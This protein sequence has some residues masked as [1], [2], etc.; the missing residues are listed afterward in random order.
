LL[1]ISKGNGSWGRPPGGA[2][3]SRVRI[4]HVSDLHAADPADER[5]ELLPE[6]ALND[7]A[8][9]V[10]GQ[11]IH[12]LVCSGDLT[13][14]GRARE[15]EHGGSLLLELAMS[16][17]EL[18]PSQVILVPGNHEIDLDELERSG[19]PGLR[20]GLESR[21]QVN[22]ILDDPAEL[23]LATAP[24]EPWTAFCR[25][26]YGDAQPAQPSPLSFVH[27]Y[28]FGDTSVG[29]AALNSAWLSEGEDDQGQLLLGNHQVEPALRAISGNEIRLVVVHHPLDWLAEFDAR[30]ARDEFAK[31]GVTVLSGHLHSPEAMAQQSS[32]GE[33]LSLRAGCL[34]LHPEYPNSYSLIEID[35]TVR[36]VDVWFRRWHSI[37]EVFD[38]DLDVAPDGHDKFPLPLSRRARELGHPQFSEVMRRIA[39]T[40]DELRS[41]P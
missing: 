22:S 20:K 18:E 7:A 32:R 35:P 36:T 10:G 2:D 16:R 37:R 41:G 1:K 33:I 17:F 39:E 28:T 11:R 15:Y 31:H 26:F 40:A 19:K 9:L 30:E 14:R 13:K 23:A 3:S 38:A 24:L 21:A 34:Y 25:R 6:A 29:V 4:L 12:L 5:Q 8:A 27:E